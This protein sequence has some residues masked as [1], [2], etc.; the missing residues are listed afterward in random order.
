MSASGQEVGVKA[1]P[2]RSGRRRWLRRG[3]V[4]LA[5]VLVV[6]VIVFG[7]RRRQEN[8]ALHEALAELDRAD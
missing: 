7:H 2:R 1:P 6:A 8:A 3:A 5:F 4:G